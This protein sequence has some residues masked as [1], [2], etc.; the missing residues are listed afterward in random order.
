MALPHK[1]H[2]SS[3]KCKSLVDA[4]VLG[5]LKSYREDHS[6][7]LSLFAHVR[8]RQEFAQMFS[9]EA[10]VFSCDMNKLKVGPPTVS[11][12]H[13]ISQ[14]FPVEDKPNVPHHDFPNP[15]YL[16][17]SSGYMQLIEQVT[18]SS[19]WSEYFEYSDHDTTQSKGLEPM[20][21]SLTEQGTSPAFPESSEAEMVNL[22]T[23]EGTAPDST[24]S[25]PHHSSKQGLVQRE[26]SV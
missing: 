4:R 21:T 7:Q 11:C 13:Q 5:K 15:G 23:E 2:R 22:S 8:Y 9:D 18:D 6:D 25:S 3:A 10:C 1:E 14:F 19:E 24:H 20:E 17:I 16:L 12:Y 26:T